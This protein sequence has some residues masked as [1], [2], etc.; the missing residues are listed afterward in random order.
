MN[1]RLTLS[2]KEIKDAFAAHNVLLMK[3]D[4]T[5]SDP[6]ITAELHRFGRIGVPFYL[7]YAPDAPDPLI[8][9]ELLTPKVIL[10]ALEKLP[11]R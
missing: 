5:N 4:W 1:E 2:K 6:V 11:S 8:L 7:L 10:D 9:P 3:A